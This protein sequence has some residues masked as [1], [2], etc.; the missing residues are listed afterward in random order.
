M[1]ICPKCNKSWGDEVDYC[2]GC[3]ELFSADGIETSVVN[4]IV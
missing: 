2:G 4:E 1:K 3:G